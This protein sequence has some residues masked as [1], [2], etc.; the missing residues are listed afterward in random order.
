VSEEQYKRAR[1]DLGGVF[2]CPA[3]N[4]VKGSIETTLGEP[5]DIALRKRAR[6]D[7][8][9]RAVPMEGLAGNLWQM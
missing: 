9:K 3:V 2:E 8:D 6:P 1:R 4:A 7:G 5:D